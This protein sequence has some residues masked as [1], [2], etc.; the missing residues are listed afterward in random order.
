MSIGT[1]L[2]SAWGKTIQDF[3]RLL[4]RSVWIHGL[5]QTQH[6]GMT[7]GPGV[8]LHVGTTLKKEWQATHQS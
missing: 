2:G 4:L 8:V 7:P 3:K 5:S 1:V 6:Q